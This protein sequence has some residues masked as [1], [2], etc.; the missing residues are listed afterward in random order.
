MSTNSVG[1]SGTAERTAADPE[2]TPGT[3]KKGHSQRELRKV[4]AEIVELEERIS[5]LTGMMA[6]LDGERARLMMRVHLLREGTM[7]SKDAN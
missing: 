1:P 7:S 4:G 2:S 6:Q 3:R 5:R